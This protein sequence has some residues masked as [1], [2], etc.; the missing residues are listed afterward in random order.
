M[1]NTF[2][3]AWARPRAAIGHYTVLAVGCVDVANAVQ[4]GRTVVHVGFFVSRGVCQGVYGDF[5]NLSNLI[6][7]Y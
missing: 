5:K 4:V 2:D 1:A 7:I 6:N 3:R